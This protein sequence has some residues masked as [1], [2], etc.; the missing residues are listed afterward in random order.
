[1]VDGGRARPLRQGLRT[2]PKPGRGPGTGSQ[3]EVPARDHVLRLAHREDV[4][5]LARVLKTAVAG[6]VVDALLGEGLGEAGNGFQ[7]FEG[8][9]VQID[10]DDDGA[11]GGLGEGDLDLLAIFEPACKVWKLRHV[12]VGAQAAG[13]GYGIEYT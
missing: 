5:Q 12:G 7:L 13:R 8:R 11:G 1:M 2:T 4:D 3:G 6:A 9:G 10:A